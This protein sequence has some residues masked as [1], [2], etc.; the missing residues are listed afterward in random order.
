MLKSNYIEVIYAGQ[1]AGQLERLRSGFR[2]TYDPGYLSEQDN[3]AISCTLPLTEKEY[4]TEDLHSFFEGLSPQGW[5]K[6]GLETIGRISKNDIFTILAV[7]G[8]DLPGAVKLRGKDIDFPPDSKD[9]YE[10][11][12]TPKEIGS[13]KLGTCLKCFKDSKSDYHKKCLSDFWGTS[14]EPLVPIKADDFRQKMYQYISRAS[15]SG[16]QTKVGA[17]FVNGILLPQAVNGRFILKPPIQEHQQSAVYEH[18]SMLIT[19]NILGASKVADSA[20]IKLADSSLAYMTK[21]FDR[22]F[23]AEDQEPYKNIHFEDLSQILGIEQFDG[24]YE[25]VGYAILEHSNKIVLNEF[26]TALL[27]QFYIGNNDFHLKNIALCGLIKSGKYEG[28]A[29]L[30]DCIN[31]ESLLRDTGRQEE[32]AISFFAE[33]D[34]Y[35]PQ[36]L[37]DGHASYSTFKLLYD[38]FDI[39]ESVLKKELM[40]LNKK[41]PKNIE[42]VKASILLDEDKDSFISILNDRLKKLN[43]HS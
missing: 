4:V 28:M 1:V 39:N 31:V 42:I 14:K 41:H 40:K 24:S 18:L 6:K 29:P 10:L 3:L 17:N 23:K 12:H 35:T 25:Q 36:F 27:S 8:E 19:R 26:L 21:R 7:N 16:M 38:K 30:Y 37:N 20:I 32:M 11:L 15:L 34:F 9:K 13:L 5:Y 22:V 33:E 2:F 43:K